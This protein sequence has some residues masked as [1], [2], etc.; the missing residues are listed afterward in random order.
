MGYS[1]DQRGRALELYTEVQSVSK[2]IQQLG[3]PSKQGL[4]TWIGAR[5][6]LQK[7]KASRTEHNNTPD[8]PL[9][10]P[11]TKKL[12]I[13]RRC[14]ELG[15]NIQLVSEETGYSRA[16]IYTWRKKYIQK[17]AVALMNLADDP[18]GKLPEGKPAP[19]NAFESL[20]SQ[21]QEM[22][23]EIDILK[24]IIEVLKKDPGVDLT[25]LKNREKA[26]IIGVIKGK[27][28][29]PLLLSRLQLA[30]SS[31]Y[32]QLKNVGNPKENKVLTGRIITLFQK[33]SGRYSYR[34][35][36][37]LLVREGNRVSEKVVRRIMAKEGLSYP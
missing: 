30:R 33:N 36:H 26:V 3:Y 19:S 17:G 18:R 2:V 10:P 6:N 28:P 29:L 32:Y 24:E 34:R 16:S 25:E 20:K 11:L 37:A 22:Q 4:Y 1:D 14:F 5:N 13:L 8:H 9:H 15:E 12:D 35:I 7:T 27:Y 23:L 21:L 31:Y